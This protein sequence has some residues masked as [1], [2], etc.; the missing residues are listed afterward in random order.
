[1]HVKKMTITLDNNRHI[2][3]LRLCNDKALGLLLMVQRLTMAYKED[4]LDAALMPLVSAAIPGVERYHAAVDSGDAPDM[5][6][7]LA[8]LEALV[9]SKW[10]AMTEA[11]QL[12]YL[13][14]LAWPRLKGHLPEAKAGNPSPCYPEARLAI[15]LVGLKP[16]MEEN[17]RYAIRLVEKRPAEETAGG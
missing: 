14:G 5:P 15:E 1:M 16:L 7:A 2:R 4:A 3:R 11:L 12:G 6:R 17:L 13:L 9:A 10:E 8:A